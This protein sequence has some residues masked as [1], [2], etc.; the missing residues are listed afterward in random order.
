MENNE[1]NYQEDM[2]DIYF[3]NHLRK[4]DISLFSG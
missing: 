2:H 4:T 3:T 1:I